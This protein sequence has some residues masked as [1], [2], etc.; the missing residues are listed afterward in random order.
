MRHPRT[1]AAALIAVLASLSPASAGDITIVGTGDGIDMLQTVAAVFLAENPG[2]AVSVPPSIGSGGA[3]AAVGGD[4]HVL[5]RVARPLSE[6]E[7]AKGLQTIPLVKLPAAFFVHPSARVSALTA[8]QIVDIYAGRIHNW[9]EVGGAD[10]RIKVVRREEAD[11]TLNVLRAG[12]PGWKDLTI[13]SK[14]KLAMTTQEAIESVKQVEGAIGFAPFSRLLNQGAVV[15]KV[16]G[17][18]P[19]D[20]GYPS[21]V[22]LSIL[23]KPTTLTPDA[24][25]FMKFARSAKAHS[26]YRTMGGVPIIE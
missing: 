24:R 25:A 7:K 4:R 26:V 15:L 1:P 23:Y 11:S 21:A 6:A 5:G 20:R 14:S 19:T 10:L 12:M 18:H 2:I 16:D 17:R 8:Q 13:T 22:V 3:V 9:R